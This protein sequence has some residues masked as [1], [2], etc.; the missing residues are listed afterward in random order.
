V[1]VVG[2]ADAACATREERK[3][4][5]GGSGEA[6]AGVRVEHAGDPVLLVVVNAQRESVPAVPRHHGRLRDERLSPIAR[7][8]RE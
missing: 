2:A 5:R 1:K 7:L 4:H 8:V 6:V 3:G